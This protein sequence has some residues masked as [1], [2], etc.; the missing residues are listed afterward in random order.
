MLPGDQLDKIIAV[1]RET[2]CESQST[3]TSELAIYYGQPSAAEIVADLSQDGVFE[4][5]DFPS[6]SYL[7]NVAPCVWCHWKPLESELDHADHYANQPDGR[8]HNYDYKIHTIP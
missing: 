4:W 7:S 2:G 1:A 3:L 8:P 6:Q 5:N